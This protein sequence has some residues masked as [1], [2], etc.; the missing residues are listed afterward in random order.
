MRVIAAACLVLPAALAAWPS[1]LPGATNPPE[2]PMPVTEYLVDQVTRCPGGVP[3]RE[4]VSSLSRDTIPPEYDLVDVLEEAV[5]VTPGDEYVVV[6][7]HSEESLSDTLVP[8][9][10]TALAWDAVEA[11]PGWMEEDLVWAFHLLSEDNQDRYAEVILDV[12]DSRVMDEVAFQVAHLSWTNIANPSWDETLLENNANWIYEIE[13]DLQYVR[14]NDYGGDDYYS[15]TEYRFLEGTDDTV[16]VEIPQEI[17]YW[18][19]VMPKV[20]DE[21]PLQDSSVYGYFWREYLYTQHD[22]GYP[23]LSE[24][25]APVEV[26]WDGLEYNWAGGRPF[27]DDM[28]AVDAIGNWCSE[29]VPYAASGNRPIQPNVIAH[30]HDGNCGELQDLLSAAC[31]TCLVPALCTMDILEDHVWCEMWWDGEWVPYQVELGGNRTQINNPGIAYDADMGGS[32]ECSCIWDWRNDGWSW[33]SIATYSQTCTLT[34]VIRD[35]TGAPVDHARVSIGSESYYPPYNVSRGTWAVTDRQGAATFILG[36]NQNYYVSIA[37]PLGNYPAS[38]WG[39]LIEDSEAGEHYL[40]EWTT[41][42]SVPVPDVSAETEGEMTAYLLEVEYELPFDVQHD[43]DFYANPRNEYARRLEDGVLRH[44]VVDGTNLQ[45]YLDDQPFQALDLVEGAGEARVLCYPRWQRDRYV[46][47]SGRSNIGLSTMAE[48][49]V[50]L[51]RHDGTGVEGAAPHDP[52]V[53][54]GPN[55]T[56]GSYSVSFATASAG[57][58]VLSVYDL[59]G[60]MV[61]SVESGELEPGSHRISWDG[62]DWSG[63]P[64]S[65]GTYLVRLSAP[66]VRHTGRLLLLR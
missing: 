30:E 22:S 62:T 1:S 61:A 5:Y 47:L 32:K 49:S 41:P 58:A 64:A 48:V 28:M 8:Y 55:P 51:W 3:E 13:D 24:V 33:Q 42:D 35:S 17:Y 52:A 14:V 56:T 63:S 21:L 4:M 20:S 46:V 59:A 7:D 65:R 12:E 34:V 53:S 27:T 19:I 43:R 29:T 36:N 26:L 38:G 54:A 6:F 25:M 39:T 66:G 16:W 2:E 10:L 37:S 9:E 11:A 45:A 50:S 44:F 60:R 40:W 15:T 23:L 57:K 18:W 31:R